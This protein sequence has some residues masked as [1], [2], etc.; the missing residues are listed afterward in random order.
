MDQGPCS[1]VLGR[2]SSSKWTKCCLLLLL[3]LVVVVVVL[4]LRLPANKQAQQSK[5]QHWRQCQ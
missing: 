1:R 5:A 3:L 2:S 4:V